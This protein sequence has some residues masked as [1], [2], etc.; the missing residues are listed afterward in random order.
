MKGTFYGWYMKCQSTT[1]TL[2][3]IPAMHQSD[4]ECT[5]SIQILTDH[6][7]WNVVLPSDIG[8]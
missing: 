8:Q 5:C 1:E 6:D 7:A 4:K 2:A 3:V